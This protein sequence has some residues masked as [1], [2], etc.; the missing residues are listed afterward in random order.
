MS[1][2]NNFSSAI[3]YWKGIQLSNLQKELDQQGLA[4]VEKQKDGLVSRKKLAEQTRAS[5]IQNSFKRHALYLTR[6]LKHSLTIL[7]AGY[8]SEID[9]IT[10]RT[11]YAES[12]FLTVYKLLADA[13]DPAPLFEAAVDQSA[14]MVDHTALANENSALRE[15]LEKANQSIKHYEAVEKTNLELVQKISTMEASL[16]E[17]KSKDTSNLEQEMKDQYSDKIRQYKEREHDLQKRLNQALDQLTDLRQSHDDTQAQLIGHDQKYDEEVIGK[18]AELDMVTMDLE[19]ANGRIIQLEKKVDDLKEENSK[20]QETR[21]TIEGTTLANESYQHDAEISKL[22]K[23]VE[24]YKDLFKKTEIRL[25]KKIKDLTLEV[26]SLAEERDSLKKKVKGFED[27]DEIKRELQIMKYVEF[28]TGDDD[29]DFDANDVLKRDDLE[30]SLEVRLMEKNKK[31][32][33][34]YT[35]IKVSFADLQKNYETKSKSLVDLTNK[36]NDK[37]AL[38]QRLEEDLLRIG[39]QSKESN[40]VDSLGRNSSSSNFSAM[41]SSPRTPDGAM[42]PHMDKNGKEDKSILPIVMS[43]RDRFRQRNAELEERTRSLET[44]LQDTRAE[45]QNLKADNLKLF[46]RLKFV[47]VWKEQQQENPSL[48][49]RSVALNMD[50][51]ETSTRSFKKSNKSDDPSDK[52]GK[53]YEETMNPFTQFH[54]KEENRRY[55]ALN[56]AEKL[57]LNLTRIL[58]SHKWSRY[59]FIVYSLLLH[60]LVVVTLYQLSLWECRHDHDAIQFPTNNDDATIILKNEPFVQ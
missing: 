23:D 31:L 53:I 28:S 15:Q 24:T 16:T 32:E 42:T 58:F 60:L 18:L 11:K 21:D 47:H 14:K 36:L 13:P 43:Q 45:V 57:T 33:N 51:A 2:D 12:S 39:Q 27:Y 7:N 44:T 37:I 9:N 48:V 38:I 19:R 49:N 54:R 8:Q 35:Q 20:L 1:E 6:F 56:P 3:H 22:I 34:E 26:K 46:E 55:N 40:I 5:E 41:I 30:D 17:R 59:F 52:Y 4:I 50:T 10:K 25:S 29:D